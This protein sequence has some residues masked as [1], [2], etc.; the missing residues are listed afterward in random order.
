MSSPRAA[1]LAGLTALALWSTSV[2]LMRGMSE[3]SGLL[4]G[5]ALSCLLGGAL[6]V[7]LH[8]ARGRSPRE[9]LR[10]PWRYLWGCGALFVTTNVAL[11][12]AIG[13]CADRRQTLVIGLVNYL[14]PALTV[15]LSVPL[16]GLRARPWLPLGLLAAVAGTAV[17]LLGG[18]ALTGTDA[19]FWTTP[20]GLFALGAGLTAAVSWAL[21][22]NLARRWGDP[23][24]GA[25]PPFALATGLTL[26]LLLLVH[27]E[28]VTWTP[29]G[30]AEVVLLGVASLAVAYALWDH[31][32]RRGDPAV[33]GLASTFVPIASTCVSAL[34]LGVTPGAHVLA[35]GALVVGGAWASKRALTPGPRPPLSSD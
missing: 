3:H 18:E 21:Y 8:V 10:L 15:G 6:G 16:L 11:Y 29:R 13:A 34:Y 12:L 14:W 20:Q 31:G 23:E 2:A 9:W 32:F 33:L 19:S 17:A 7:G 22:S 28:T 24:R 5:P 4:T 27:P 30:V 25:V 35:G 1:T 26:A